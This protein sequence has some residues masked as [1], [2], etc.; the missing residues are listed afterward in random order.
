MPEPRLT[1]KEKALVIGAAVAV[2][3]IA[4]LMR[5]TRASRIAA[6]VQENKVVGGTAVPVQVS[7]LGVGRTRRYLGLLRVYHTLRRVIAAAAV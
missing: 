4:V 5:L 7:T 1:I 6:T 3:V 2:Q